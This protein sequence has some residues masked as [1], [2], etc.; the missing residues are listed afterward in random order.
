MQKRKLQSKQ[1]I[2]LIIL[3][4]TKQI[5]DL[6]KELEKLWVGGWFVIDN[7][8]VIKLFF[9]I[10]L[11]DLYTFQKSFSKIHKTFSLFIYHIVIQ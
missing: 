10:L 5:Q 9:T 4:Y 6:Y 7:L 3:K 11:C 8:Y 2:F 1:K